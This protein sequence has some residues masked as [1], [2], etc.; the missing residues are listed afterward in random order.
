MGAYLDELRTESLGL[1]GETAPMGTLRAHIRRAATINQPILVS[2]P[3]GAGK[4]LVVEAIHRLRQQARPGLPLI[5]V[6]CGEIGDPELE[7][8]LFG[9][10]ESPGVLMGAPAGLIVLDDVGML[11]LHVQARLARLLQQGTFRPLGAPNEQRFNGQ[12]VA[13]TSR[14]LIRGVQERSFRS[15]LLYALSVVVIPVPSLEARRDDIPAL[16]QHFLRLGGSSLEFSKPALDYLAGRRWP[17]QVRELAN[18]VQ[19]AMLLIRESVVSLEAVRALVSPDPLDATIDD[20]LRT[21]ASRLLDL[22]VTN[23][24]AAIESTVIDLAMRA[25]AGNKSAAARLLGLNRKAVERRL[26]KARFRSTQDAREAILALTP[27][28]SPSQSPNTDGGGNSYC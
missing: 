12:V 3:A 28:P 10:H 5:Q 15:D 4:S 26:G 25:S 11:P 21:I 18:V 2:G 9:T 1:V 24:L 22:P 17:G 27:P 6:S 19:R 14:S 16:V 7:L 13:V 20:T 23:K 8:L